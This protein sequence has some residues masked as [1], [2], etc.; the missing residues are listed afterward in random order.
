VPAGLV[1]GKAVNIVPLPAAGANGP[2]VHTITYVTTTKT[3]TD[4]KR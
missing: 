3:E 4:S 1:I 2:V